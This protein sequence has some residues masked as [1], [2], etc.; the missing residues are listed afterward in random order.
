M[1]QDLLGR[2]FYYLRLSLTEA[3]NFRCQY[4]LPDGYQPEGKPQFLSL[5]EISTVAQ[6][7]AGLGTQKIRLTG[8]EPTLR[9]DIV[10]ITSVCAE[11][12]GISLLTMTTHGGRLAKLA[13]PLAQAGLQQVNVSIDSLDPRQFHAIT[14]QNKLGHVLAGLDAALD[15]GL[16]VKTNAVLMNSTTQST[17]NQFLQWLKDK[18]I[19]LRFIE[20]MQTGEQGHFFVNQHVRAHSVK[21]WLLETGWQPIKREIHAGPAQEFMHEDYAGKV[22]LITPYANG[23][24]DTCNRLRVSA[25]GKLHLC[26][27]SES[28]IDLRGLIKEGDVA[29][30]QAKLKMLIS[31]KAP[32]HLLHEGKSGATKNLA[33]LGG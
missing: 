8:G 18:P 6:A 32:A 28:G 33:M 10:D 27:F 30:L 3:C 22:G 12:E 19:T 29:G 5:D 26:L 7:F 25:T 13:K 31:K 11:V 16:L 14:G 15:A 21:N 23:F 20:L 9:K 2:R 24:C 4:C 17:I 1:L